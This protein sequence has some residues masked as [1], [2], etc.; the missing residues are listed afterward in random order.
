[1]LTRRLIPCLDVRDGR[2]VKGVRFRDH[3]DV[4]DILDL[5]LRY[6]DDGADE[7]VFYDIT[8][9]P[10]GREVDCAWIARVA[11]AIDIPFCVAGGIASVDGARAVLQAGADKISIN[12]PALARPALINE[13]AD[14]FGVQCVVVGIDSLRD[15]DGQWRVRQYSGD[16]QHTRALAQPTL[17]W[18]EQAIALGAGEVVLN[19]MGADGVREGYDLEQLR[20]ARARCTVPLVASG[21]AGTAEHFAAVFAEADVDAALAASVFHSGQVAIPALKAH[22]RAQGLA[23]RP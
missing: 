7:L 3:R 9:S 8:A 20:A 15:A 11:A 19:C 16:P 10:Q 14:A 5:A 2:V 21:G 12:S 4:G 13:L 18:I 22:L 23:V 17:D 1:M 6:R